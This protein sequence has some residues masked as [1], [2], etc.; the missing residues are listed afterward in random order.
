MVQLSDSQA[1]GVKGWMSPNANDSGSP[2]ITTN[3]SQ[4]TPT[5]P[6]D[7]SQIDGMS[8]Q[9]DPEETETGFNWVIPVAALGIGA[10]LIKRIRG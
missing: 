9:V 1:A 4:V 8:S 6:T 2:S 10:L 3:L 5:E 7:Y